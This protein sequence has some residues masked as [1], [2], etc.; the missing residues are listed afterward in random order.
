[1][2]FKEEFKLLVKTIKSVALSEGGQ[3]KNVDIAGRLNYNPD[4]FNTLTGKSG[5]VTEDHI[6]AIKLEFRNELLQ[7]TGVQPGSKQNPERAIMLALL[8]DYA[9]WKAACT[10]QTYD[11]VKASI[12]KR[13]DRILGGLDSWL[14]D[15]E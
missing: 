10:N 15:A 4:Y 8:E 12:K 7:A 13:G 1:M 6:N 3:L 11:E 5:K 2:D 14:P 9:E